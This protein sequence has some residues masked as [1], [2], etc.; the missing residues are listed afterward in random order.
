GSRGGRA[1][2]GYLVDQFEKL[3]LAGGGEDGGYFQTFGGRYRNLLVR[4][5]GSDSQR[6][7]EVIVV[8]AH[9]DHV[10]YGSPTN[11]YGPTGYIH[12]GAD[13]NASGTAALLE[14][15]RGLSQMPARPARTLLFAFWDGEEKGLLGSKHWVAQPT[16]PLSSVTAAINVDMVGRL[17]GSGL[18]VFGTRTSPGLR[19]LVARQNAEANVE[20]DFRW[21]V[22]PNSDHYS[23]FQR[24]IP[25]LMLHTGLHDDYHRPSDDSHKLNA[26]GLQQV[27]RLMLQIV[28]ELADREQSPGFR[29]ESERE[30]VL[31]RKRLESPVA[32]APPRLG[33]S[34]SAE[35]AAGGPLTVTRV[36]AGSPA[37]RAGIRVGQ[38]IRALN[39]RP[40]QGGLEFQTAVLASEGTVT[41][42]VADAGQDDTRQV[43]VTLHGQPVRLGISW[44][45]DA[46]EPN[47]LV[48]TRVVSGSLAHQA[49][50]RW[51]DRI[52]EVSGRVPDGGDVLR[53]AA[54]SLGEPLELL[55]E[56]R[57]RL[58]QLRLAGQE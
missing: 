7:Q 3:G 5:E 28:H 55:V 24:R 13:D 22:E 36:A 12:N 17:R 57:G 53:A 11:S 47:S 14:I 56:R 49:G 43:P 25:F 23:F 52:L 9:Y 19:E 16:V 31:D 50:L 46:A 48:V 58:L 54:M 2:A 1:A 8:G 40:I 4:L 38:Q 6:K 29:V 18:Q 44:R 35:Q 39:G 37:E 34:W 41:L 20:L 42:T 26:E 51:N 10:G 32:A 45:Q 21:E 33:L 15:L 27:S 30:S